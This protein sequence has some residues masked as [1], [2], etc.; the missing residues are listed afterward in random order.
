MMSPVH[1]LLSTRLLTVQAIEPAAMSHPNLNAFWMPTTANRAFKASPRLVESA[2]GV[3][4]TTKD[5]DRVI[6]A[7]AG[8]WCTNAGHCRPEIATAIQQ[9]A[10]TLDYTSIFNF[11]HELGFEYANRLVEYTPEGIDHVFF[12]TSGSEAVDTALKI[13]MQYWNVKGQGKKQR[14]IGRQK[15]YHG[16]SF[17]GIAVGGITKNHKSFG[18][19]LMVDHLNHTLDIKNSAFSKGL[20][21]KGVEKAEE[22]E[23]LIH[24]HDPSTIAAVIVEPIAG[25]GGI[26]MPPK[27]Y[28]NRL[29]EICNQHDILLIFDEVIC[30]WGRTGSSFASVEFDVTPDM[31][32]SA[33]GITNGVVPLSAVFLSS[34]IYNTCMENAEDPVELYHGYT[35]SCHPVAC[36]AGMAT[37][38]IYERENLL[39]RAKTD[40]EIGS[41]W[42]DALHNL[43]DLPQVVDVRN[44]GLLGAVELRAPTG[45][46]GTLGPQALVA[47]WEKGVMVRGIGDAI[48]ISPPL[49]IEKQEIDT[50]VSVLRAVIPSIAK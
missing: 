5:G 30:G 31:I 2:D 49:I 11:A 48:V 44:Y 18:Q 45:Q 20:P 7:T 47:C 39:S 4:L 25:A 12:G 32:T 46:A 10:N 14:F 19:W 24:F 3:F 43:A 21:E 26:I 9:Q 8:L 42:Q 37:L 16:V 35:Y 27:G 41:Y 22:L 36:A 40:G 6:D 1:S 28:L 23:Q 15:S 13:A 17:G 34:E 33:K 29:R 50:I 38:D